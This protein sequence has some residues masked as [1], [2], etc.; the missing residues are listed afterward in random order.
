MRKRKHMK[1]GI[2]LMAMALLLFS[3][4]SNAQLKLTL[5]QALQT[6]EVNSPEIRK[7]ELNMVQ[8]RENLNAQLSSLKSNFAL[9]VT[10]FYYNQSRSFN[11]YFSEWNTTETLK[12]FGNLSISQPI[13]FT[14]GRLTLQNQLEYQD[15]YSESQDQSFKGFSNNLYLQYSQPLFR[16]NQTKLN[17]DR[18]KL[19]LE[20]ATLAYSINRLQ[21]EK[22]V[23]QAFYSVYQKQLSLQIAEEEYL[24]Q[25]E[26]YN[27]IK[28]KVDG[29]LSAMEEL[30]QAELNL[31]TSKSNLENTQV[32][33]E[34]A[35]DQFKQFIGVSLYDEIEVL[36]DIEY[37][38]V[39]VDLDKAIEHGLEARMELRQ[40]QINIENSQFDLVETE[41][42]DAFD[43]TMD[44]SI[45][46]FGENE[47]IQMVYETPTQSPQVQVSFNVPLW[48]WG[49][50]KSRIKAAEAQIESRKIEME[51]QRNDI[52]INIRQTYRNLQNL[53]NQIEIARQNEK[54]AQLTYDINLER[55]RNGDL[56]SMD[57][58]R[59][60]NQLSEK[61]INLTNALINYKME[62]LNLK[63]QSLWD[64]ENNSSFVPK[65]LQPQVQTLK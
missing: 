47:Q 59:F 45:G 56:T 40:R 21:L 46:L 65:E 26:S 16:Y 22:N 18:Y 60:Q 19:A 6:A 12:S 39:L 54:N 34:N 4:E 24:N 27:I 48:D 1:Y 43:G 37:Q 51:D 28:S 41:A 3:N 11:E 29:G 58:S 32:D 63:I 5:E 13:E 53:V 64:F 7:S 25:Q 9:N 38:P 20:N 8:N 17:L 33:L 14:D 10:P 44:L 57:L 62:L 30:Y 52:I 15:F 35:K 42:R 55:Y 61:K 50:R 2:G 36:A 49:A 23:T 31:A